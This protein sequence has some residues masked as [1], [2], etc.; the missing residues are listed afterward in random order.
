MFQKDHQHQ[1]P[2]L[3]NLARDILSIP[4]IGAGVERLFNSAR[5]ICHYRRGSLK[6]SAIQY[7]MMFMCISRFEIEEGQQALINK[8]LTHK[9][10]QANQEEK[11]ISTQHL[12]PISDNK[13]GEKDVK[14]KITIVLDTI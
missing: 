6:L 5:D 2:A 4:A 11:D 13:K 8:Y 9:E 3:V 7:L 10:I 1:F 12:E 14:G